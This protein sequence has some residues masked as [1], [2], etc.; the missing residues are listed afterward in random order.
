[1]VIHWIWGIEG[2]R[3]QEWFLSVCFVQVNGCRCLSLVEGTNPLLLTVYEEMVATQPG[4][5]S[6]L[7]SVP[8]R[9]F[10][11]AS[12]LLLLDVV[13]RQVQGFWQWHTLQGPVP[14]GNTGTSVQRSLRTSRWWQQVVK[15]SVGPVQLLRSPVPETS[16]A[17]VPRLWQHHFFPLL[18]GKFWKPNTIR[19][20]FQLRKLDL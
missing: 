6:S 16:P 13:L 7:W 11:L 14:N 18:R 19:P 4:R 1:M 15:L 17:D 9:Q 10:L 20:Q 5:A 8:S 12:I 3:C 2:E